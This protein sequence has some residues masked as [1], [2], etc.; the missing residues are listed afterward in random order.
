MS[1][2]IDLNGDW[3]F[4]TDSSNEGLE[5]RWYATIPQDV[6][7]IT[8][9]HIWEKDSEKTGAVG[10]YYKE[11]NLDEN[12]NPKRMFL[13]F[14]RISIHSMIWINGK[15]V[16]ENFG[17]Y[18]S[19]E[20]DISKYAKPGEVNFIAVR[21]A[22]IDSY[23]R[24]N[25]QSHLELPVGRP[26]IM[27]AFSGIYGNVQLVLGQRA[28]IRH[29]ATVCDQDQDR[30]TI[31][32]RFSNPRNFQAKM[33]IV[34]T[35]PEGK[36]GMIRKEA[37]LEKEDASFM[38]NLTF[39]ELSL[40]SPNKPNLY[41]LEVHLEKSFPI[42]QKFGF[43]KFDCLRGGDYYLNDKI[44]K[45]RG[46]FYNQ[47]DAGNLLVT[48]DV[49]LCKKELQSIKSMGFN[50][51]RSGGAP[52]PP[53]IL[54]I[55]DEIGLV[56][57]Q[58]TPIHEQKSSKQGLEYAKDAI[59]KMIQEDI[60]HPSVCVWVM[61]AENSTLMLENG[62]K[63]LKTLDQ[64]DSTRPG[65][66]NINSIFVD[67]DGNAKKDTGKLLAV[68]TKDKIMLYSSTRLHP[69]ANI[70]ANFSKFLSVYND[71]SQ[72]N[73][74]VPD[75]AFGDT[76]FQDEYEEQVQSTKGK[77]LISLRN[78]DLLQDF[79][80]IDRK[81]SS[82]N[83]SAYKNLKE[84][85][86]SKE[87]SALWTDPA[88]FCEEANA[89][90]LRSKIDQVDALFSNARVSG[91][92]ID[93]WADTGNQLCGFVDEFRETKELEEYGQ[94]IGQG[95]R[96]LISGMERSVFAKG[97]VQFH[98]AILNEKRIDDVHIEAHIEDSAG[99]KGSL[100]K[101]KFEDASTA[102]FDL[103]DFTLKVP[104][105]VGF[106]TLVVSFKDNK[107][108]VIDTRNEPLLIL[109]EQSVPASAKIG[110]L[111][112][113]EDSQAALAV[114]EG[115][116]KIIVTSTPSSWNEKIMQKLIDV[117][118]SGKTL[119][120]TELDHEDI[121]FINE[122]EVLPFTLESVNCTGSNGGAWHYIIKHDF[123]PFLTNRILDNTCASIIPNISLN[124]IPD[125]QIHVAA[126]SLQDG[127]V[128]RGAD[129]QI[130]P[131]G[132]GKLVFCQMPILESLDTSAVSNTLFNELI[133]G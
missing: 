49:A 32:L 26:R 74:E 1:Q 42:I 25:G 128:R 13:R 121:A 55:C 105:K 125:A 39:K 98:L 109:A 86:G 87:I 127:D 94:R 110:Y 79:K 46:I 18:H 99:K 44:I 21:V 66:S 104:N 78:H 126:V 56:V 88:A 61:G 3:K 115:N 63:L 30:L 4:I 89:V 133:R 51:I 112:E 24:V 10:F 27:Q 70:D 59:Q 9:P 95:S 118:K 69:R 16:G 108:N 53:S 41:T 92:F 100:V 103:G 106:A 102:F 64:F 131:F 60:N 7:D 80:K 123:F 90:S 82:A 132:K 117:A 83:Q 85:L 119:I 54:G 6:R 12:E 19:I 84:V 124:D 22:T 28:C 52:L 31:E 114:I 130:L 68:T 47:E 122:C 37:R 120:L 14:E 73:P 48:Q 93:Q 34:I 17:S 33:Q 43:R 76:A 50:A 113:A 77:L 81:L 129:L 5:N 97:D 107:G 2:I 116:S 35:D 72:P 38:L 29:L 67:H 75:L 20:V 58:E 91:I 62:T 101:S 45:I 96:L 11:F 71:K 8:V 15:K 65:I 111:D 40:W 36:V 57:F 23:G